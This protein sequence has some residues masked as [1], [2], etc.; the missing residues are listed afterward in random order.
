MDNDIDQR[1]INY[2]QEYTGIDSTHRE[3]RYTGFT[4]DPVNT[5]E[6]QTNS[7]YRDTELNGCIN[8][9]TE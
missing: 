9:E 3:Y 2:S 7:N 8:R 5:E 4:M 1:L 6:S